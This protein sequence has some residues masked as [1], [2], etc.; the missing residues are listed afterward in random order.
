MSAIGPT[1]ARA[2]A[3]ARLGRAPQDAL[4]AAV[5]LEAWAGIRPAAAL[6]LGEQ[7]VAAHSPDTA[8][9][10]TMSRRPPVVDKALLAEG[11]A[12]LIAVAAVA[13]WTR[14]FVDALGAVVWNNAVFIALPLAIGMQ[15][16]LRS[17][18][19]GRPNGLVSL[20]REWPVG[21]FVF[22]LLEAAALSLGLREQ[23]AIL[24]IMTWV[25]GPIMVRRGWGLAY[26]VLLVGVSA[27][28][29]LGVDPLPVLTA[30][31]TITTLGAVLS[32]VTA[33][34]GH[35][36]AG[37]MPRA[38]LAGLMGA[39]IG[40]VLVVDTT[41]GWGTQGALPAI[42]LVP[43]AIGSFWG[44]IYLW[45]LQE[46]LPRA[47]TGVPVDEADR[48]RLR[49]PAMSALS[50]ALLRLV[51]ITTAL[52][53][54]ALMTVPYVSGVRSAPTATPAV[55][56]SVDNVVIGG[57]YPHPQTLTPGGISATIDTEDM[58]VMQPVDSQNGDITLLL[59]FGLVAMATLLISLLQALGYPW[60]ALLSV[61]CGLAAELALSVWGGTTVPG[62]ALVVGAS[63]MVIVALPPTIRLCLRP[64]RA[65]ATTM[66]IQ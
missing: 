22:V 18:Y 3:E 33:E 25:G 46:E 8:Q 41:I 14:P 19:L 15:W 66:W 21:L 2:M 48:L 40:C 62:A 50:G 5:V 12:L 63:I 9:G 44:G 65:L 36:A 4:E 38:I 7:T 10:H 47:L 42:A 39:G 28:V 57:K 56:L 58:S 6:K 54:V 24:L 17:R 49:G 16:M 45:R 30:A 29:N 11:T 23:V 13:L 64:G 35:E 34:A 52:S 43:S 32:L 1:G 20:K 55:A 31:A 59:G 27:L 53:A 60:R 51:V 61:F 37:R 26:V